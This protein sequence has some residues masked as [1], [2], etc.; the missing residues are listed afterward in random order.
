M[1]V[2]RL[3]KSGRWQNLETGRFTKAPVQNK[4]GRWID[5]T[6]K[7]FVKVEIPLSPAPTKTL[8]K[9]AAKAAVKTPSPNILTGEQFVK[10]YGGLPPLEYPTT[11][12]MR[13]KR[14]VV[15]MGVMHE[16]SRKNQL[17]LRKMDADKLLGL[18]RSDP[19]LFDMYFEYEPDL[20]G[21]SGYYSEDDRNI[22]DLLIAKYEARYGAIR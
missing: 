5:P 11:E 19:T 22:V 7:R 10:K 20:Y 18:Y 6:T 21:S 14:G 12:A 2:Y 1:V 17:K 4:S 13:F 16:T 9:T 3:L 15:N 8:K